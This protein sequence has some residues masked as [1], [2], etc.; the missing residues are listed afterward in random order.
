MPFREQIALIRD[1]KAGK[2][3]SFVARTTAESIAQN[4]EHCSDWLLIDGKTMI[5]IPSARA[6][7]D[8]SGA[9]VPVRGEILQAKLL[10][11]DGLRVGDYTPYDPE[12]EVFQ[13]FFGSGIPGYAPGMFLRKG[14]WPVG[15]GYDFDGGGFNLY[16][17]DYGVNGW[18]SR[19]YALAQKDSR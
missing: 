11:A 19:G 18:A 17:D 16:A 4:Y 5:H 2:S 7:C 13:Y 14:W 10:S 6:Q 8:Q 3:L 12:H 15:R 1:L 9:I